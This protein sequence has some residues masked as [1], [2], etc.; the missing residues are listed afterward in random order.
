MYKLNESKTA[1]VK[2]G[3]IYRLSQLVDLLNDH[4]A[5]EKIYLEELLQE[6]G[7]QTE[8]RFVCDFIISKI[9]RLSDDN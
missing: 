1:I 9:E 8:H 3:K 7:R 5:S 6:Y 2:D 4:L